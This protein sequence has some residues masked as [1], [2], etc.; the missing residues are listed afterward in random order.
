MRGRHPER[1][2]PLEQRP[3][4]RPPNAVSHR[5]QCRRRH[6]E[7]RGYFRRRGEYRRASGR[8]GG[9][10]RYLHL[11]RHSRSRHEKVAVRLRR[12]RRAKRQEHRAARPRLPAGHG[13]ARAGAGIGPICDAVAR[14][15]ADIP[16]LAEDEPV[17]PASDPQAVEIEFWDSI[18]NSI[19]ANEYE[20]YLEQ[21]PEGSF[22]ALARVR[23]EAIRRDAVSM[24]DPHDREIELSFW[25]TVRGSDNPALSK[26]ISKSIPTASSVRCP[27]SPR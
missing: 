9:S 8:V 27:D 11:A 19:L 24:R 14:R 18:K 13:R 2:R 12:P 15:E 6:A 25:E 26:P 4:K 7:G 5:N 21:Y 22:V 20:A 23:L 1:T 3:R 17:A 16:S 10:R